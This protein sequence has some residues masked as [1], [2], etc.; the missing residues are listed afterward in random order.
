MKRLFLIAA[1]LAAASVLV[2]LTGVP[3][4]GQARP[5]AEAASTLKTSWGEP[6]LQGIWTDEF[7]SPLQRPAKYAG[8]EFFTDEERAAIDAKRASKLDHDFR[9]ERGT[10]NDVAGAYNAVFHLRKRTGRRTSLI[11]DPPDGR[12]PP[13]QPD[14]L[15]RQAVWRE[16]YVAMIQATS[17]CKKQEPECRGGKFGPS[18]PQVGGGGSVLPV[19]TGR[20]L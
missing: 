6:D 4:A 1:T 13:Y 3:V 2:K 8:R 16:F 14:V 19:A 5:A 20:S 18:V 7:Q 12:M 11:V 9:A 15:K 17:A 10:E